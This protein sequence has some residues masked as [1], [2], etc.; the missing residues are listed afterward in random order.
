MRGRRKTPRKKSSAGGQT[1]STP[2]SVLD[3][4]LAGLAREL[5]HARAGTIEG[6]HQL[7]VAARRMRTALAVF[8]D[9]LP[10]RAVVAL[11]R[12]LRALGHAVG[13]VRDLDV[14]AA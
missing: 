5:G 9:R 7:R 3:E 11:E 10:E 8:A 13:T 1:A 2:R 14:L 6:V 12:D 4:Q